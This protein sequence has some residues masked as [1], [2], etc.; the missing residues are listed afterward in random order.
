MTESKEQI[1][2]EILSRLKNQ[3]KGER[4]RKS[5]LIEDKIF[6]SEMFKKAD[7]VMFYVSRDEEVDTR[8]MIE[9]ALRIGKRVAV[10]YSDSETNEIVASELVDPEKDLE[11]SPLGIYQP[12]K[13]SSLR[14]IPL[15]EI[16]LVIV[17]GVAFDRENKRLGR[18]KGY[19]D[20]FLRKLPPA[21]ITIGVCF[22]FQLIDRLPCDSHDFP[23]SKVITN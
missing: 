5:R 21:T 12:K 11:L 4:G 16:N 18:G 23:V 17:P 2:K 3:S 8:R 15:R 1:R 7:A 10:P 20:R 14:E 13:D 22:D 19:Y 6:S 9:D